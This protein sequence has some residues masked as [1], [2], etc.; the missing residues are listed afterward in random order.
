M[1]AHYLPINMQRKGLVYSARWRGAL[2]SWRAGALARWRAGALARWR[3]GALAFYQQPR[4]WATNFHNITKCNFTG[5]EWSWT[6]SAS[7]FT[8]L[9]LGIVL[10]NTLQLASAV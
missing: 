2:A 9:K 5:L 4:T 7:S 3:A 1:F 6:I 8:V 10:S